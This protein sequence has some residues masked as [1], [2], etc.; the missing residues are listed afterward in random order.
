MYLWPPS[1]SHMNSVREEN[2]LMYEC[3]S[4]GLYVSKRVMC[5]G[6][7][8]GQSRSHLHVPFSYRSWWIWTRQ[9]S[10]S[11]IHSNRKTKRA[12][13]QYNGIMRHEKD[14]IGIRG[15]VFV[16]LQHMTSIS[17]V[18][19][20]RGGVLEWALQFATAAGKVCITPSHHLF[21]VQW[22]STFSTL[23]HLN[24]TLVSRRPVSAW[25]TWSTQCLKFTTWS[26]IGFHSI[27]L[28]HSV[29]RGHC[30]KCTPGTF[31]LYHHILSE[32]KL[33]LHLLEGQLNR[34]IAALWLKLK[35]IHLHIYSAPLHIKSDAQW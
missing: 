1:I 18:S 24:W 9:L 29:V 27:G 19:F 26:I 12:E 20:V 22:Q 23:V 16:R 7:I 17:F 32:A 6:R 15:S 31:S 21:N 3:N 8:S 25:S 10:C 13:V 33:N 4:Y 11:A 35:T 30:W 28:I 34:V 2:M 5:T 14:D